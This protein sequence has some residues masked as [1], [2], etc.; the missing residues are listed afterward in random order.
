VVGGF[1]AAAA[2]ASRQGD[3]VDVS[4]GRARRQSYT[5]LGHSGAVKL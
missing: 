4:S 5:A 3:V 1:A 2:A